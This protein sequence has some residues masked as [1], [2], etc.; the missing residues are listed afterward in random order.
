MLNLDEIHKINSKLFSDSLYEEDGFRSLAC[1]MWD[2]MTDGDSSCENC[3]GENF[4]QLIYTMQDDFF[5]GYSPSNRTRL[6]FYFTTYL[7]WLYLFVERIDFI[8]DV[9]NPEKKSK[10]F[11]DFH[12][13]NF[14]TCRK[15]T[16][17]ANFI[18]HPKEFVFA[19]WPQYI[20]QGDPIH[21]KEGI[22]VIDDRFVEVNYS[23][24]G[25][26]IKELENC[27]KVVVA[28]PDLMVLT[29]DFCKELNVFFNFICNNEIISNYLRKKTTI[30][31]YYAVSN[32]VN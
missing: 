12:I 21:E 18:K 29:Q 25:S 5:E 31:N 23:K 8:F 1:K 3:L 20:I 32:E 6:E 27:D 16:K 17:W 24:A 14:K 2:T 26:S 30:Q 4:N 28:I 22:V 19:H 15:I 9:I 10:L 13:H 7:L 11:S